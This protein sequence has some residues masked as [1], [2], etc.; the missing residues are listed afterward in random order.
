[1]VMITLGELVLNPGQAATSSLVPRS[2]TFRA[3]HGMARGRSVSRNRL[4]PGGIWAGVDSG[5][6]RRL[7]V[8]R[9][10][11]SR[12][13]GR[14]LVA[15]R[16]RR[17]RLRRFDLDDVIAHRPQQVDQLVLFCLRDMELIER[18][19]QMLH[20]DLELTGRDLHPVVRIPHAPAGVRAGTA[21][22]LAQLVDNLLLEPRDVSPRELP[23]GP[24]IAPDTGHP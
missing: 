11:R 1:M 19:P 14:S 24:V 16:K 7:M 20:G 4:P 21:S 17:P 2:G 9:P 23:V 10:G 12:Q 8:S 5:H 3:V 22:S 18:G 6:G 15:V 13:G